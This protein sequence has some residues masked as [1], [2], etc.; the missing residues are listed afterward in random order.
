VIHAQDRKSG[1]RE[2]HIVGAVKLNDRLPIDERILGTERRL[3]PE[4]RRS[5]DG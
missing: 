2:F 5:Q 4:E 3:E 1:G